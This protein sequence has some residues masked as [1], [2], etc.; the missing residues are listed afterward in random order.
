VIMTFD[1]KR[2]YTISHVI[3]DATYR[4]WEVEKRF[5]SADM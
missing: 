2:K 4:G 1:V 3:K 5:C